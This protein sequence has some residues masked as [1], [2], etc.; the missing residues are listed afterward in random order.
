MKVSL[1]GSLVR[2]T[3][4]PWI[5]RVVFLLCML[6]GVPGVAKAAELHWDIVSENPVNFTPE[7]V[8][9]TA[10]AARPTRSEGRARRAKRIAPRASQVPLSQ[11]DDTIGGRR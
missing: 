2:S 5:A 3:M 9:T 10:V 8:A 1:F 4:T 7:L 6:V 11:I